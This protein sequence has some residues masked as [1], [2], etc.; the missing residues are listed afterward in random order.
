[1]KK[2]VSLLVVAVM[3]CCML[4]MS[5]LA[6]DQ[7]LT[8][9][10]CSWWADALPKIIERFES[11]P[12]N[13]G[14]KLKIETFPIN[15]YLDK[16]TSAILGGNAAD[17]IDVDVTFLGSLLRRNLLT[18]FTAEDLADVDVSDFVAG[19]WN[20]G[21]YNGKVYA[22]PNRSS[23]AAFIYNK[24]LFDQAGVAYPTDDWTMDDFLAIC[25]QLRAGLADDQYPYVAAVSASDPSNFNTT[26][27]FMYWAAGAEYMND[28]MTEMTFNTPEAVKAIQEYLDLFTNKYVPEGAINY[29]LTND[30]VPLFCE[31][32]IAM[33]PNTS[34]WTTTF[35]ESGV[36]YG[37]CLTPDKNNGAGGYTFVVPVTAANPEGGKKF[38]KWF[39][40]SDVLGE[41]MIRTPSRIS[42]NQNYEPWNNEENAIFNKA[43]AYSRTTPLIPEWNEIRLFMI[44]EMQKG[45][46][47]QMTA[48]EIADSVTK[49]GNELLAEAAE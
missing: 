27:D 24:D 31:G 47:G 44:G 23:T 9:W 18:E 32:K 25:Q 11:D 41:L 7:T 28:E 34:S 8:L 16:V 12:A 6:A 15:G 49:Y 29:T 30:A 36:N 10:M 21:V 38:V 33:M 5:A 1:M 13:A 3:L 48:Q 39:T 43:S 45:I 35:A 42:T 2:I 46:M 37:V 20:A 19:A 14:Y 4:P 26:F 22:M 17:I 40:Q